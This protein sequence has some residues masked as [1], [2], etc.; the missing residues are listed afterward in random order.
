MQCTYLKYSTFDSSCEW[1]PHINKDRKQIQSHI[2]RCIKK[3]EH[4]YR[5]GNLINH[6]LVQHSKSLPYICMSTNTFNTPKTAE[7]SW[8]FS[9][10]LIFTQSKT[11]RKMH[12]LP[13]V[14]SILP[15]LCTVL[16]IG[17]QQPCRPHVRRVLWTELFCKP[18]IFFNCQTSP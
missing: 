17:F 1:L 11:Y 18:K 8:L 12:I 7:K 6:H 15:V 3:E 4:N 9:F 10:S 13:D 5:C 2:G 16:T 14:L